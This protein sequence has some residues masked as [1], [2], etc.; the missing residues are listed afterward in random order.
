MENNRK[1]RFL[2]TWSKLSDILIVN[3]LFCLTCLPLFTIPTA[4]TSLD[5]VLLKLIID[6]ESN[7]IKS[8]LVAFKHNFRQSFLIGSVMISACLILLSHLTLANVFTA[9]LK[10]YFQLISSILLILLGLTSFYIFPYIARYEVTIKQAFLTSFSL[11][12]KHIKYTMVLFLLYVIVATGVYIFITGKYFVYIFLICG[13]TIVAYLK[14][15]IV[16]K[17]FMQYTL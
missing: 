13:F 14:N 1:D 6:D 3:L 5:S 7:L 2:S 10:S 11:V 8:Y 16:S 4:I 17:V 15:L 9:E 12:L